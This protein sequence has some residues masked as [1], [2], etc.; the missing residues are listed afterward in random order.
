MHKKKESSQS[1]L[2]FRLMAEH[3]KLRDKKNPPL[4]ILKEP[5]ITNGMTVL[6]YGCGPGSFTI[7]AAKLVGINGIVY[8]LD[9][10]PLALKMVKKQ[11]E[12]NK[13]E[14]VRTITSS[15]DVPPGSVDVVLLYDILHDIM[16]DLDIFKEI[17]RVLKRTGLLSVSDHHQANENIIAFIH[18][19]GLFKSIR[20]GVKTIQFEKIEK[21]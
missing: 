14:Q 19:T 15:Q 9:I 12:K 11:S 18:G 1:D 21:Q 7:A 8:A 2:G 4:E 16:D 5:G 17:H 13:L 20:E 10:H 3:M 6:D